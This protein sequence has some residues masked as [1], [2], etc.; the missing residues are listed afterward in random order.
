M[1]IHFSISLQNAYGMETLTHTRFRY[2]GGRSVDAIM[3][4]ELMGLE[5][6]RGAAMI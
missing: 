6:T 1:H 4:M 5:K 2:G 3:I